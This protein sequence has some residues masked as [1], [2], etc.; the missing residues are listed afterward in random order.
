LGTFAFGDFEFDEERWELR[1]CGS[2]VA[3]PPKVMQTIGILLR[4]RDRLVT[5]EELFTALWPDVIVTEASLAKSIRIA[6][7]VLGDDG[8][9]QR[10]IKTTRGRGYRFVADVREL[11]KQSAGA[12]HRRARVRSPTATR[13]CR[14]HPSS[15]A[16]RSS[17]SSAGRCIEHSEVAAV[18]FSFP[19][20]LARGRLVSSRR[21]PK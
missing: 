4:N 2:A 6:R 16:M 12:E 8:A 1:R 18:F 15:A 13:S 5:N 9:A 3:V 14:I 7:Q 17:K 20:M 11:G 19:A 10:F 21:S